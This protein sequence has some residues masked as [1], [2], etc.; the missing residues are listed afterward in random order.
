MIEWEFIA[1]M[2]ISTVLIVTV[3]GVLVLRPI[4]KRISELLEL[5]SRD[6]Q[7]GVE[8]GVLQIRDL[9]ET[10]DA[11][12]HLMEE[13]QEF[14]EKLLSSGGRSDTS[15]AAGESEE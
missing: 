9:L 13:R 12:L 1:P 10:M 11:R 3:G 5:Y 8:S 4:S 14:T 15:A 6:R 7:G 2:F